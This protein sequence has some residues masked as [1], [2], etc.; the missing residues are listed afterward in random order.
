MTLPRVRPIAR[1]LQSVIVPSVVRDRRN[2]EIGDDKSVDEADQCGNGKSCRNRQHLHA[3]PGNALAA[4][5]VV[6][7]QE[8]DGQ[9]GQIGGRD[10]GKVESAG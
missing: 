10:D 1:P 8:G 2:A 6:R 7:Q 9:S 3:D 5:N 4:R